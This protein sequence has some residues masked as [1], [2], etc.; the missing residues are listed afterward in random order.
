M[1]FALGNRVEICKELRQSTAED[2]S[3]MSRIITGDESWV[4]G[5]DPEAKQQSTQWK[6]PSSP[7]PQKARQSRSAIK[8]ML[9]IFFTFAA[10]SIE[11]SSLKV[12]QSTRNSIR[13]TE[14][15]SES[16]SESVGIGCLAGIGIG[17]GIGKKLADSDSGPIE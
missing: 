6:S 5:Y 13:V 14:S 9:I 2:P 4:Y 15:E 12:K 3:L 11:N 8:S 7:R 16:E 10:L 17:I 1:I